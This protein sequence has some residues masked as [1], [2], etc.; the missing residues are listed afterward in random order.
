MRH[1]IL[2]NGAAGLAA[3]RQLRALSPTDE[4]L[5]ISDE[6]YLTYSRCLLAEYIRG[7]RSK[8]RLLLHPAEFYQQQ[9]FDLLL[10][11][12]AIEL[13]TDQRVLRL[14]D[15]QRIDYDRL[16]IATGAVSAMPPI[17]GLQSERVVGLRTMA[18]ADRIIEL[19]AGA[20]RAVVIGGGY[21][22]LEAAYALKRLGLQVT[23]L[24]RMPHILYANLDELAAGIITNDLAAERIA[25]R[26]GSDHQVTRIDEGRAGLRVNL[27]SNES[28]EADFVVC[29]VGVR[30]N[31]ELV[32]RTPIKADIGVLVDDYLQ[33][34]VPGIYSAGDVAQARDLWT[35][36]PK[37]TP[38]WPNAVAQGKLAARNMAGQQRPYTGEVGLQ[39]AV[40]FREVPAISFGLCKATE[41]EGYQVR[42]LYRPQQGIY[43]KVVLQ[44]DVLKG[45]I[46][47]GDISHAG[48]LTSLIKSGAHLGPIAERLL[49]EGFSQAYWMRPRLPALDVV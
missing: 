41:A 28:L 9:R 42:T 3:A 13:D 20:D 17:P 14:D 23:V 26:T 27:C 11:R 46:L 4:I 31:L 44:G 24:E 18:D 12:S 25:I 49:E 35:G 16:L 48:V 1:V 39:N 6:P 22:G 36:E 34:N 38:I 45:V 5:I 40:E 10:G 21:I 33:T 32:R 8:E 30:S 7:D 2:G 15:G 37:T 47:V 29:A 19:A 43:K